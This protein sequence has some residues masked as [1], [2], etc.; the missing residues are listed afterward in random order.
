MNTIYWPKFY[1]LLS[2]LFIAFLALMF[3]IGVAYAHEVEPVTTTPASGEL[4]QQS[5]AE[6]RL[7]FPEEIS[8]SGSTLQ[9]FDAAGKQVDLGGGGVDLNDAQ[10]ATLVVKV[11]ALP[12]GAYL[13]KWVITLSDGDSNQGEYYF[14]IGNVTLPAAPPADAL[15]PAA[16]SPT[17]AAGLS[18]VWFAAGAI[19]LLVILVG[20]F[21]FI[22][23][24]RQKPA[25]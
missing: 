21:F 5:P 23:S 25:S 1:R 17:S 22:R 19:L 12:E 6:V 14:G 15:P 2:V 3:Q 11:P 20:V 24:R 13:V 16:E 8:E 9:I 7:T 10:H 18:P 4:L